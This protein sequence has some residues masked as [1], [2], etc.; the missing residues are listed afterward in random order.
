MKKTW[1]KLTKSVV[2]V[3]GYLRLSDDLLPEGSSKDLKF[4]VRSYPVE[5]R[6]ELQPIKNGEKGAWARRKVVYSNKNSKSPRV[7]VR[8][9]LRYLGMEPEKAPRECPVD[10]KKD[11]TLVVHF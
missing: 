6:M 4:F 9:A 3:G 7:S 10:K 1:K 5:N 8:V 11:G 2:L